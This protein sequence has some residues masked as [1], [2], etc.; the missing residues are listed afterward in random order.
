M[1]FIR[2]LFAAFLAVTVTTSV[3][4]PTPAAMAAEITDNVAMEYAECAAYFSI[5]NG[6]FSS[7]GKSAEAIKFKERSDKAALFSLMAAKQSRAE[8]MAT[9]VTLAR[10]EMNMKDMQRTIENDYS[11]MSLLSN[12]YL[13]PCVESMQDSAPLIKR[14]TERI[15]EKYAKQVQR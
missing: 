6:A 8:E 15:Q 9:K 4:Q 12:K 2:A 11:N 7:S 1:N 3:A 13:T 5:V 14:W 10:I